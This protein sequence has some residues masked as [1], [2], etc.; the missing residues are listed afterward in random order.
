MATVG[1]LDVLIEFKSN[2][3]NIQNDIK[4]IASTGKKVGQQVKQSFDKATDS[5][6]KGFSK[7]RNTMSGIAKAAVG[8][9]AL[10]KIKEFTTR[11]AESTEQMSVMANL[12]RSFKDLWLSFSI[13]AVTY[14]APVLSVIT[15]LTNKLAN[16]F[17][18]FGNVK[19]VKTGIKALEDTGKAINTVGK[20]AKKASGGVAGFDE[21]ITLSKTDTS[22]TGGASTSG[23]TETEEIKTIDIEID[24]SAVSNALGKIK[25]IYGTIKK[26]FTSIP[27][28]FESNLPDI[29]QNIDNIVEDLKSIG[30]SIGDILFGD[31]SPSE[32]GESIGRIAGNITEI[33]TTILDIVLDPIRDLFNLISDKTD[34][35][36]LLGTIEDITSYL[37]GPGEEGFKTFIK[38]V[39]NLGIAFGVVKAG[40]LIYSGVMAAVTAVTTVWSTVTTIATAV[41]GAFSAVIAFITSPIGLVILAIGA[42]IAIGV[43]LYKNWD[44]IKEKAT[45]IFNSIGKFIGNIVDGIKVKFSEIIV[46]ASDMVNGIKESVMKIPE[47]F[48]NAFNGLVN[49]IK[50]PL[51][52]IIGLINN[53]LGK[54]KI[55]IPDWVP[56]IGG[57]EFKMPTIPR[58]KDGG[59]VT[60]YTRFIAGEAGAEAVVPLQNSSFIQSF[61]SMVAE[62][63]GQNSGNGNTP[64]ININ[65]DNFF[66]T[67][68]NMR[69]LFNMFVDFINQENDR[70][71]GRAYGF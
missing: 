12:I 31:M 13:L 62:L 48:K 19:G 35:R 9:F 29:K 63:I 1:N 53:S 47:L 56:V 57:E 59:I 28:G 40:M 69:Q 7:V 11:I 67:D 33:A 45:Q 4:D 39:R 30:T 25:E 55:D 70:T 34:D 43:L 15:E 14:L 68:E 42:L 17:S 66:A 36:G 6:E 26:V 23:V 46:K 8:L 32:I 58:L 60:S 38:V 49:I 51:N 2:I 44:T 18:S 50:A 61:A 22:V 54:I 71:G 16:L 5:A 27:I 65:A 64:Q 10:E 3:K 37:T 20:E 41:G 52:G 24:D 21:V